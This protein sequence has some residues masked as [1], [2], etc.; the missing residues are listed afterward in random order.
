M[1]LHIYYVCICMYAYTLN[2]R[3]FHFNDAKSIYI[4]IF[5]FIFIGYLCLLRLLH[6]YFLLFDLYNKNAILF[7]YNDFMYDCF[8]L[9]QT[10]FNLFFGL[11]SII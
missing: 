8:V 10:N 2:I 6:S 1:K 11:L 3:I 9:F 5:Y 7:L 4:N